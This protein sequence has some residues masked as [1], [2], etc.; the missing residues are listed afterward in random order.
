MVQMENTNINI[1]QMKYILIK[2][3]NSTQG[4]RVKRQKLRRIN[5]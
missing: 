1:T 2:R 3:N 5:S 4:L